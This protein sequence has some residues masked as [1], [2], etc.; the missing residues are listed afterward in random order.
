[1]RSLPTSPFQH[2]RPGAPETADLRAPGRRSDP[3]L[4]ELAGRLDGRDRAPKLSPRTSS[5]TLL[6]AISGPYFICASP[7]PVRRGA[8]AF[9]MFPCSHARKRWEQA[10]EHSKPLI[11]K[12]YRT[13]F[14]CSQEKRGK[15]ICAR[16]HVYYAGVRE[17]G[18]TGNN[19]VRCCNAALFLFP[20]V[21]PRGDLFP[22]K[23]EQAA[24]NQHDCLPMGRG[25]RTKKKRGETRGCGGSGP[26]RGSDEE[27]GRT[28]ALRAAGRMS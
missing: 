4:L 24:A 10:W 11:C 17:S 25:A 1:V 21:F 9:R 12:D 13:L 7:K 16:A 5:W 6:I 15:T 26:G 3:L 14:P 22:R 27:C 8:D 19:R 28:A 18:N 2:A 23:W 20:R